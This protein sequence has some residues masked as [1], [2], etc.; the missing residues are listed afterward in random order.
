M[1]KKIISLFI[2]RFSLMNQDNILSIKRI[3]TPKFQKISI[4]WDLACVSTPI[5][6]LK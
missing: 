5:R 1:E 4:Y 6:T 2:I 3:R